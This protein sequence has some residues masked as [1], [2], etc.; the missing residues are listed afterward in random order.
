M[1]R[2][3]SSLAREE[4][5][6]PDETKT[7]KV[8]GTVPE[9]HLFLRRA[10]LIMEEVGQEAFVHLFGDS[11]LGKDEDVFEQAGLSG[12]EVRE[13]SAHLGAWPFFG[14]V[15]A[16]SRKDMSSAR[17]GEGGVVELKYGFGGSRP[18]ADGA[19]LAH[20]D[21]VRQCCMTVAGLKFSLCLMT[22]SE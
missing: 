15:K 8:I 4:N 9:A 22:S 6:V 16:V 10:R 21:L 19:A 17:V 18:C 11:V 5:D 12:G 1:S 7:I 20:W 3:Q 2:A 13:P 14:V